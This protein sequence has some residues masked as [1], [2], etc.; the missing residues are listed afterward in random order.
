MNKPIAMSIA[1]LVI[2]IGFT[3]GL[4]AVQMVNA[5]YVGGGGATGG[6]IEEQLK[7]G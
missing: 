4:P 6:N 3:L 1:A 5:Q 7:A 2:V